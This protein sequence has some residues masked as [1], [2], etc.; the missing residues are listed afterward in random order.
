MALK[1]ELRQSGVSVSAGRKQNQ[2]EQ[3]LE[4][5]AKCSECFAFRTAR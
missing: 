4:K 5:S 2:C 1:E 3:Q